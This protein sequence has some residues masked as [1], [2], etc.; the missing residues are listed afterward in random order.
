MKRNILRTAR[1][2][3]KLRKN[4]NVMNV[5]TFWSVILSMMIQQ[6]ISSKHINHIR[7]TCNE[8][9]DALI[10]SDLFIE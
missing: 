2:M 9:S 10:L 3:G 1:I 8:T 6:L 5:I 4:V 7:R